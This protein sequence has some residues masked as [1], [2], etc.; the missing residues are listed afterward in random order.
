[1]RFALY[2]AVISTALGGSFD[3]HKQLVGG[4]QYSLHGIQWFVS[5][6]DGKEWEIAPGRI[7]LRLKKGV[8]LDAVTTALSASA[9]VLDRRRP[10]V[11]GFYR[12]RYS[13]NR[14]PVSTLS[15]V[16]SEPTIEA[17]FLD[18]K[19]EFLA[20][21][22][23][24]LYSEQWN[25]TEIRAEKGWAV[26]TGSSDVTIA[27]IDD[28]VEYS[29]EDLRDVIWSNPNEISGN[30]IDDDEDSL[31]YG[32]P[33]ADDSI[34]WDFIDNDNDPSPTPFPGHSSVHG[35][36]CA[37]MASATR[38]NGVGL[39][40]VAGGSVSGR[41]RLAVVRGNIYS[42]IE[43]AVEYCWRKHFDVISM[44]WTNNDP[45]GAVHALL[46]SAY[47]DGALLVVGS[48]NN[49]APIV[50]AQRGIRR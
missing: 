13:S 36:A 47:A 18:T 14:D 41:P 45:Y 43:D 39:A 49:P 2:M 4:Q 21:P 7:F 1:M 40:G 35:T 30:G 11:K 29:H 42:N 17:A 38:D 22:N 26:T 28:G 27:I 3:T 50:Y 20:A 8:T 23:D 37:G 33:L 48:G 44:S 25:L 46:D 6:Q 15:D 32:S 19:V 9:V 16:L 31:W 12:F 34:G 24:S 10:D 5:D